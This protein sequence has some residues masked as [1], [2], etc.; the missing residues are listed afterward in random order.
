[1]AQIYSAQLKYLR[2]GISMLQN[3]NDLNILNMAQICG[4]RLK[5]IR[6]SFTRFEMA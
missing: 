4:K 5:Y 3:F 6:N 1:M 2:N